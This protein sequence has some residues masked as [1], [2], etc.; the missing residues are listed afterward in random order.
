MTRTQWNERMQR[1]LHRKDIV[2]DLDAVWEY[3][4][5]KFFNTWLNKDGRTLYATDDELLAAAPSPMHHAG[6][7]YLHLLAQDDA[8]M[9]REDRLFDYAMQDFT[10][11]F[12][13]QNITPQMTRPYYPQED[14][15]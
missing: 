4:T 6:M 1:W 3:A 8:G 14:A 9:Q 15:T 7:M 5:T 2:S 12:S 11:A 13:V 10:L